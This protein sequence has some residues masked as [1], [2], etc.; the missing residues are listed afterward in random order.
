MHLVGYLYGD[1]QYRQIRLFCGYIE[2]HR[3]MFLPGRYSLSRE[4][5]LSSVGSRSITCDQHLWN[6]FWR[7]LDVRTCASFCIV[8]KI[9]RKIFGPKR[10]EVTGEWRRLHNEELH[11]YE[12]Y[13]GDQIKKNERGSE[14]GTYGR[15]DKCIQVLVGISEEKGPLERLRHF[16][17]Q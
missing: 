14:C 4:F 13:L 3:L 9:L 10:D 6:L 2:E 15:Q 17:M 11:G 12:Y 7:L 8:N 5:E 1:E 16:W